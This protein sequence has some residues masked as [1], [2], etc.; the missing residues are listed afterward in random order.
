MWGRSPRQNP[1]SLH[2]ISELRL[3]WTLLMNWMPEREELLS[4]LE[5]RPASETL[6]C[7]L[8]SES[9][10]S[11]TGRQGLLC[12]ETIPDIPGHCSLQRQAF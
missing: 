4:G 1:L 10:L 12:T 11:D 5:R 2:R 8:T 7:P 9:V 3:S 6:M